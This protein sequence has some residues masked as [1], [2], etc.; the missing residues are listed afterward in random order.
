MLT[1]A[2]RKA[3]RRTDADLAL[4]TAIE[5]MIGNRLTAEQVMDLAEKYRNAQPCYDGLLCPVASARESL[6][7]AIYSNVPTRK[8]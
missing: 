8:D 4:D 3:A 5:S 7:A 2:Q 1:P 6:R